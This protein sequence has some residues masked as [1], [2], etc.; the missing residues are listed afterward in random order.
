MFE[1][2]WHV[3]VN[4]TIRW[5]YIYSGAHAFHMQTCWQPHLEMEVHKVEQHLYMNTVVLCSRNT[6]EYHVELCEVLGDVL[7]HVEQLQGGYG[8]SKMDEC[9]LMTCI[10]VDIL[11]PFMQTCQWP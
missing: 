3:L 9:Q 4:V 2:T 5:V 6:W 10:T 1:S 11:Y 7:C 8:H